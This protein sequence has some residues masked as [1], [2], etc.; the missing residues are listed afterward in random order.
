MSS[1]F[2]PIKEIVKSECEAVPSEM[3]DWYC[4]AGLP[5][6]VSPRTPGHVGGGVSLGSRP[7][8]GSG[9]CG[10]LVPQDFPLSIHSMQVVEI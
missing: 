8:P 4:G 5:L 3:N 2:R 7:G 1:I 6:R 10:P 9:L